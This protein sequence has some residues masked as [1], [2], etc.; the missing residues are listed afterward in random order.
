M[1]CNNNPD[2][3]ME[4]NNHNTEPLPEEVG[5]NASGKAKPDDV[6]DVQENQPEDIKEHENPHNH[7]GDVHPTTRSETS[8]EQ[9]NA[10]SQNQS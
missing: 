8:Q 1:F 4:N 3:E 7:V 6:G 10:D 5:S 2:N 9:Q